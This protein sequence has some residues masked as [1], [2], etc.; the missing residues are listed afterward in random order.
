[1]RVIFGG[2]LLQNSN[3]KP[4]IINWYSHLFKELFA[5]RCYSNWNNWLICNQS[6]K[7][8]SMSGLFFKRAWFFNSKIDQWFYF[9]N[10]YPAVNQSINILPLKTADFINT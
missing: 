3:L 5:F 10:S 2:I 9:E 8:I 6:L 4:T 1:M 7:T